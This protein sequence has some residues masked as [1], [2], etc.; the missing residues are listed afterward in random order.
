L[1]WFGPVLAFIGGLAVL[2]LKLRRRRDAPTT[3]L[4]P[5]QHEAAAKL[6]NDGR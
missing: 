6:L 2:F 4:S 3:S 5:E 1:L